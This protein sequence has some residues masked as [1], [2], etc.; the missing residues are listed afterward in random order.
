MASPSLA[1]GI[2]AAGSG[3]GQGAC[4]SLV[5]T[6]PSWSNWDAAAH[7]QQ[8]PRQASWLGLPAAIYR[9]RM[10]AK[11][12]LFRHSVHDANH[13]R[14]AR[15]VL[16]YGTILLGSHNVSLNVCFDTGSADLWVPSQDCD[17][18]SCLAHTR[19]SYEASTTFQPTP[20]EFSIR[21]GTGAVRGH[22]ALET[23]ALAQPQLRLTRQSVGLAVE[24]TADFASASCD[25]IFGLALPALAKE[26]GAP[27]FFRMVEAG[28]LD[29]PMFAVWLSPDPLAEPAGHVHFGGHERSRYVGAMH[30]LEVI[31]TKYWT[32]ALTGVA[33]GER[34]LPALHAEGAILDS[35]TSMIT[36]SD[37]DAAAINQ[38]IPGM[39]REAGGS[40][41]R[42]VSGCAAVD[43]LPDITLELGGFDFALT[44]R[45]YMIMVGGGAD[46]Y[47]I[48][49]VVGGGLARRLVLGDTFLRAFYSVLPVSR[50]LRSS[51]R[52]YENRL[53]W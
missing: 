6:R 22:V 46:A 35:G 52:A 29:A 30:E 27:A 50:P 45:Q 43:A 7:A 44:P 40:S 41:W 47:C 37:A 19:Y 1:A 2:R 33:V 16:Y 31:S 34:R 26:G 14:N 49:A 13:A 8:S 18:P 10:Q 20:A 11:V 5:A 51:W 53:S 24:S 3:R 42:L 15:N 4:A 36:A 32:V 23:V 9:T 17:A 12:D 21:Y 38:A 39:R 25:G 48:S 28:M